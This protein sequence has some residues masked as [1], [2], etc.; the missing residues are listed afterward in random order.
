MHKAAAAVTLQQVVEVGFLLLATHTAYVL[1]P[2][3][4][5]CTFL[6]SSG[7]IELLVNGFLL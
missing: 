4:K 7:C 3:S 6:S 1:Y 5:R 2:F